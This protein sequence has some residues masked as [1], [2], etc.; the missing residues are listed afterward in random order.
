MM[1]FAE[2]FTLLAETVTGQDPDGND[3]YGDTETPIYGAFAPSGSTEL[4]QGQATVIT[5]DTIYLAEGQSTPGPHDK[6]RVRGIV[7]DIDGTP[8]DYH[9]PHTGTHPGAVVRLV[10][11][12]G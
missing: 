1:R 2:E 5:H 7:R 12:T 4:V 3:V 8:N 6:V 10:E 11:V 9:N